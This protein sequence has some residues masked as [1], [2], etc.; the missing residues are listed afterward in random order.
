ME[1]NQ[2]DDLSEAFRE[3]AG[4]FQRATSHQ[5]VSAASSA[6][7][8]LLRLATQRGGVKWPTES[9][10]LNDWP[11]DEWLPSTT[12][13]E[14][15]SHAWNAFGLFLTREYGNRLPSFGWK[16]D[17]GIRSASIPPRELAEFSVAAAM[18][19]AD[20]IEPLEGVECVYLGDGKIRAGEL[21]LSFSG[22]EHYVIE[23]LVKSGSATKAEL[24]SH[25]G[26]EDA[27]KVLKRIR[28]KHP[29]LAPHITFPGGKGKGGYRTTIKQAAR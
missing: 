10:D 29:Q 26:V 24:Q 12:D 16:N 14:T 6:G 3:L 4:R 7:G 15:Y 13:N 28:D 27:V 25:S 18:L 8:R 19:I 23:A 21:Q 1:K 9:G 20:Q 22:Q 17:S 11:N 5:D 2:S